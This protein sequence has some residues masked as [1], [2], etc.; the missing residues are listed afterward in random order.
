VGSAFFLRHV[1]IV[2][3]KHMLIPRPHAGLSR[4]EVVSLIVRSPGSTVF[5]ATSPSLCKVPSGVWANWQFQQL[6]SCRVESGILRG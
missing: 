4:G 5:A 1:I 6:N 3:S 2:L